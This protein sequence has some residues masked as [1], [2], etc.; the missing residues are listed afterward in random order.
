MRYSYLFVS[1]V[2]AK[3][4]L[5]FDF[6]SVWAIIFKKFLPARFSHLC[7]PVSQSLR[8]SRL[9]TVFVAHFDMTN[10]GTFFD[11][12]SGLIYFFKIFSP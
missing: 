2:A 1:F 3:V 6:A 4:L 10:L 5:F 9:S 12:A 11:S 7:L 8:G